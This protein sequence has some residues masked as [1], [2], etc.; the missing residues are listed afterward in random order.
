M[1]TCG[2]DVICVR[3]LGEGTEVMRPTTGV[4]VSEGMYRLLAPGDY[5][6]E[7]EEWEFAPGSTVVCIRRD[8]AEGSILV[9]VRKACAEG[10]GERVVGV[11]VEALVGPPGVDL[12]RDGGGRLAQAAEGFDAGVCDLVL[13]QRGGQAVRVELRVGARAGDGADVHHHVHRAG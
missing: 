2:N 7:E 4:T 12:R 3:L 6:A 9:A 10:F 8:G 13:R 5:D 1:A 11:I